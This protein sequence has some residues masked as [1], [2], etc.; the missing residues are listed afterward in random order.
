MTNKLGITFRKG[1]W[2]NC[3]T[4]DIYFFKYLEDRTEGG[5]GVWLS[6]GIRGGEHKYSDTKNYISNATYLDNTTEAKPEEIQKYLPY[7]LTIVNN[8]QIY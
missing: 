7:Q 2:Y 8:Y 6:E 3:N 4:N 5:M 1:V